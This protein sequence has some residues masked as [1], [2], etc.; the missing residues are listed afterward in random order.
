MKKVH[1]TNFDGMQS[2]SRGW[3]WDSDDRYA[4]AAAGCATPPRAARSATN[5]QSARAVAWL[6]RASAPRRRPRGVGCSEP[7]HRRVGAAAARLGS[8]TRRCAYEKPCRLAWRHWH[9]PVLLTVSLSG[10]AM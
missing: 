8:P 3:K 1:D 4:L 5:G 9:G 7:T 10:R 2:E 6:H